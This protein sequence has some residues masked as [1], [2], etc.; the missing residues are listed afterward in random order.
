MIR[1]PPTSTLFPYTTLFRSRILHLTPRS[2]AG[3]FDN[4][5]EVGGATDRVQTAEAF[6]A[7]MRA[8]L[9][10]IAEVARQ[11]ARRDRKST[12]LNSSHMSISYAVFCLKKKNTLYP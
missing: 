6:V 9:D 8:R 4:V 1:R 2:L 5:L 7:V 10:K 12:R 11:A 3:I